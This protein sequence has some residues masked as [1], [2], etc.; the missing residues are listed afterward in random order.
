[1]VNLRFKRNLNINKVRV[2]L[3]YD[4][5]EQIIEQI[6]ETDDEEKFFFHLNYLL[7]NDAG[8]DGKPIPVIKNN[9]TIAEL[10][11]VNI[12]CKNEEYIR[13]PYWPILR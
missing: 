8:I 10:V 3:S 6:F 13:N 9:E 7:F 11:E 4:N 12:K 5:N 2:S 1:M